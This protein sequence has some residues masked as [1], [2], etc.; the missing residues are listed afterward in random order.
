MLPRIGL[1]LLIGRYA[2]AHYLGRRAG[3]SVTETVRAWRD[4][5]PE[6]LALPHPSWRTRAWVRR[7][8]WYENEV[9]PELRVRVGALLEG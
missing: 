5:L 1:T 6:Y 7:N 2:Q 8:P 4:H 3:R 9:I